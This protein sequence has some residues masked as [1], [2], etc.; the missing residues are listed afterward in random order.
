MAPVLCHCELSDDS[1]L[2]SRRAPTARGDLL[3]DPLIDLRFDPADGAPNSRTGWG[4]VR[5]P[6]AHR[7]VLRASP[8]RASTRGIR[9][10]RVGASMPSIIALFIGLASLSSEKFP[11]RVAPGGT[12]ATRARL[13]ASMNTGTWEVV[14]S[15]GSAPAAVSGRARPDIAPEGAC[16][17][18][19]DRPAR[20]GPGLR[21]VHR[22]DAG[23]GGPHAGI[24]SRADATEG[25]RASHSHR[26]GT[27][28]DTGLGIDT[29]TRR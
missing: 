11:G 21:R 15:P 23:G 12:G 3:S 17:S 27:R 25:P 22:A 4:K 19:E 13:R 24:R 26:S 10:T 20:R 18:L 7:F 1:R 29:V 16:G 5:W 2:R 28:A 9:R 6:L 8:V 14:V